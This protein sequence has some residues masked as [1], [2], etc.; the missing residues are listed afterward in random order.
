MPE[1]YRPAT[2][3]A[4]LDALIRTGLV[5]QA[6][7]AESGE[8]SLSKVGEALIVDQS[9]ALEFMQIPGLYTLVESNSKVVENP[10]AAELRKMP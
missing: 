9:E 3:R 4:V 5:K 7:T 6:N 2:A 1:T 10:M 8:L